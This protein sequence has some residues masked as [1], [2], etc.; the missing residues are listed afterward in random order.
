MLYMPAFPRHRRIRGHSLSRY[1]LGTSSS[2][3]SC[4]RTSF[5]SASSALCTPSTTSA[6]K[7]FPSSISSP[8]LSESALST[9]DNHCS[10][11]D[12]PADRN[13]NPW[14]ANASASKRCSRLAVRLL[15]AP[16]VFARTFLLAGGLAIA[17]FKERGFPANFFFADAFFLASFFRTVFLTGLAFFGAVFFSVACFFFVFF[18]AAIGAVYH[19]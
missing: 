19:R 9:F 17:F 2:G 13:P 6:S 11:P 15:A 18:F 14:E 12:C 3:T 10:S 1:S 7:A 5:S 16:A 8:T 4:V